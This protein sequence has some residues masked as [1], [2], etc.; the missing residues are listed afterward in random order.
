MSDSLDSPMNDE[1]AESEYFLIYD[2]ETGSSE[3]LVNRFKGLRGMGPKVVQML[4]DNDVQAI[5]TFDVRQ[6]AYDALKSKNIEIF[7][8]ESQDP[9]EN[10]KK[11]KDNKLRKM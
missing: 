9:T 10:L 6:N 11:F 4:K 2:T 5:I 3:I 1:F 8:A 7:V